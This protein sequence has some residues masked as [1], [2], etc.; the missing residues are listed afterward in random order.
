MDQR[1]ITESGDCFEPSVSPDGRS[2]AFACADLRGTQIWIMDLAS[3]LRRALTSGACNNTWPAWEPDSR[4]V[5]FASDCD[6]GFA[7]PA[8]YRMDT[9]LSLTP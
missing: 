7:L 4:S 9:R 2:I 3:G 5:V 8:L 6:R 1:P